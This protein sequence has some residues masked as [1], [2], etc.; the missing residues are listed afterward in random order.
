M[1]QNKKRIGIYGGT[2]DPLHFG[3]LNLAIQI[4]E[5]HSLD[6]VMFCPVQMNPHKLGQK[7]SSFL[8]RLNML[9][10]AIGNT[11]GFSITEV[12]AKR[13]GPSYTIDT[14][15][16]LFD[17]QNRRNI[18]T[19]FSLILGDDAIPNFFKWHKPEEIIKLVPLYIGRRL[20][21]PIDINKLTGNKEICNAIKKGMT[22]TALFEISGTDIR[23][24]L[25]K[26]LYCGHLVPEKILD[27]IYSNDLY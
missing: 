10:L 14:L 15:V 22:Q 19:E 23:I 26:K 13:E 2:F 27:Y 11:N 3:H 16:D 24:R 6:E 7:T 4:K 9:K 17:E 25:Q 5:I 18:P 21:S 12:E 8:H 20:E 1:I